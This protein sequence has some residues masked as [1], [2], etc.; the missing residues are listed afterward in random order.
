MPR[1]V[2]F[3]TDYRVRADRHAFAALDAN[4]LVPYRDLMGDVA[5]LPF[6]RSHRVSPVGGKRAHRNFISLLRDHHGG[7][8]PDEIGCFAGNSGQPMDRPALLSRYIDAMEAF[9]G[10]VN[11]AKIAL[12]HFFPGPAIGLADRIFNGVDSFGAWKN[13]RDGEKTGL[14]DRIAPRPLGRASC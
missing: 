13:A 7:D 1:G 8:I 14:H 12:D 10:M 2:D 3:G 4:I 5:F 9:Q 11:G 6:G